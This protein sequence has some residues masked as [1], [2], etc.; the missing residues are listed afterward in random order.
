MLSRQI[1]SGVGEM[2]TIALIGLI[3][4][5][6]AS[7]GMSAEINMT[8]HTNTTVR[9]DSITGQ[10]KG[11]VQ[12]QVRGIR[13]HHEAPETVNTSAAGTAS[14]NTDPATTSPASASPI[15]SDP[16][17]LPITPT[18]PANPETVTTPLTTASSSDPGSTC[19]YQ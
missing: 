15:I 17:T 7:A 4:V 12:T 18:T 10:I 2:K 16:L 11:D 5:A 6:T 1:S 13:K 14:T 8:I 19:P 9:I 3:L